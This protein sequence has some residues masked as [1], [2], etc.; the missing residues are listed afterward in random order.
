MGNRRVTAGRSAAVDLPGHTEPKTVKVRLHVDVKV[1]EVDTGRRQV[2]D[3]GASR[4]ATS[5]A[6][7]VSQDEP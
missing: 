7:A 4:T 2:D 3:L 6:L 1:E 5:A